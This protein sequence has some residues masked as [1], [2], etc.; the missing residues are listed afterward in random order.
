M[1]FGGCVRPSPIG[2]A[3]AALHA[4][5]AGARARAC[6][7]PWPGRATHPDYGHH[8]TL[9]SLLV[10]AATLPCV[11]AICGRQRCP[12]DPVRLWM[13]AVDSPWMAGVDWQ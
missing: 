9:T 2:S 6:R 10:G 5:I 7:Y 12:V 3:T 8:R 11:V 4:P 13:V 1:P